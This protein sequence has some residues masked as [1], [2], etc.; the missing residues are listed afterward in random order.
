MS[1][2]AF[3]NVMMEITPIM[4]GASIVLRLTVETTTHELGISNVMII[5]LTTTTLALLTAKLLTVAMDMLAQG[6]NVMM[7]METT[8]TTVSILAARPV[9]EMV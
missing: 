2:K 9:V 1:D 6:N 3:S 7:A 4:M 8:M 5:I